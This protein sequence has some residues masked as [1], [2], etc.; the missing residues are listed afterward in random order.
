[1]HLDSIRGQSIS[2]GK[3]GWW[4]AITTVTITDGDGNPVPNTTVSGEWSGAAS[5]RVSGITGSGGTIEFRT[6]KVRD[7]N[8][9]IFTVV[10]VTHD[11]YSYDPD[12]NHNGNS[13]TVYRN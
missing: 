2:K 3:K 12:A 6:G 9:V 5:G 7:G 4:R 13:V 8:S 10:D 1:M 11:T